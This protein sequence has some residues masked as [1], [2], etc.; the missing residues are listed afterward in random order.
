MALHINDLVLV[1]EGDEEKVYRVQKLENTNARMTIREH[2]AASLDE[3]NESIC[4]SISSLMTSYS[5]RPLRINALGHR[6]DD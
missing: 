4:K 3:K 6:L 1:S 5:M 2:T